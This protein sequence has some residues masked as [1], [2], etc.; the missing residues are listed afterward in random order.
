MPGDASSKPRQIGCVQDSEEQS[1]P[2]ETGQEEDQRI[3]PTQPLDEQTSPATP[4]RDV[5]LRELTAIHA[6]AEQLADRMSGLEAQL[7]TVKGLHTELDEAKRVI[8]GL[9]LLPLLRDILLLR[10]RIVSLVLGGS[11]LAADTG[12]KVP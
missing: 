12:L 5:L 9:P 1:H 11:G 10:D 3:D 7:P 2:V 6:V 8:G 4:N